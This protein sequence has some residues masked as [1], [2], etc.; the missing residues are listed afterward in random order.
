MLVFDGFVLELFRDLDDNGAE[1][2]HFFV[3]Q[4]G[5]LFLIVADFLIDVV[6]FCAQCREFRVQSAFTLRMQM[7]LHPVER[8]LK[9]LELF[10]YLRTV[11][12]FLLKQEAPREDLNEERVFACLKG[13]GTQRLV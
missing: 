8:F 11:F 1:L 13:E 10:R 2:R 7:A 12:L 4:A 6:I 3:H 5:D 9:Q